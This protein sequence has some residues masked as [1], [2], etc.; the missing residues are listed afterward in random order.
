[1]SVVHTRVEIEC[2][3]IKVIPVTDLSHARLDD[4]CLMLLFVVESVLIWKHIVAL[5]ILEPDFAKAVVDGPGDDVQVGERATKMRDTAALS[6]EEGDED[7]MGWI[8][9]VIEEHADCHESRR[10][11]TDLRV[12]KKDP[13]VRRANPCTDAFG[14]TD[15]EEQRLSGL[16]LGLYKE[17]AYWYI[18]DDSL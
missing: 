14:Q 1:M 6:D 17:R 11:S 4:P 18:A 10:A 5:R 16:G 9:A 7:D 3:L 13:G 2:P 8:H 15:L 12:E